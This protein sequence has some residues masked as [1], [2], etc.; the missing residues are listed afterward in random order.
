VLRFDERRSSL[1]KALLLP[2]CRICQSVN[3]KN[4]G[5]VRAR[6]HAAESCAERDCQPL[7]GAG[8]RLESAIH[9][10]HNVPFHHLTVS[11]QHVKPQRVAYESLLCHDS[12]CI[13]VASLRRV[14]FR[15]LRLREIQISRCSRNA[16]APGSVP[17]NINAAAAAAAPPLLPR[18]SDA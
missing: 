17:G 18:P 10:R 5:R 16:P 15:A 2:A 12:R 13:R 7:S 1:V 9:A 14:S 11:R 6:R 4:A 8:M 3:A